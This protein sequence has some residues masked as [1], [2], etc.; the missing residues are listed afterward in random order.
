MSNR[1]TKDIVRKQTVYSIGRTCADIAVAA[2]LLLM[3]AGSFILFS[4][5]RG[6]F[7]LSPA[8]N[9][10]LVLNAALLCIGALSFSMVLIVLREICHAIFDLA[11]IS[12][13][14]HDPLAQYRE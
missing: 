10:L 6:Y 14:R 2:N 4:V 12:L 5:Y 3:I 11:D 13:S 1:A 9:D 7:N 8:L